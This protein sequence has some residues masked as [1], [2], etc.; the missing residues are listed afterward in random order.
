LTIWTH[1][2]VERRCTPC[3]LLLEHPE[4]KVDWSSVPLINTRY[5]LQD[6]NGLG[7][8]WHRE[9]VKSV[10]DIEARYI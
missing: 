9:L 2:R 7:E 10:C 5:V 6:Q 4:R 1:F 8:W 3:Y